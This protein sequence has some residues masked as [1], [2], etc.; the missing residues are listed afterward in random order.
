MRGDYI[1]NPIWTPNQAHARGRDRLINL[2]GDGRD[3]SAE[4]IQSCNA[5]VIVILSRHQ[6]FANQTVRD[7]CLTSLGGRRTSE[8][9]I[10]WPC[11]AA[12]S[13]NG[14]QDRRADQPNEEPGQDLGVSTM[15]ARNS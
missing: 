11:R 14:R 6:G 10:F 8:V 13:A 2:T 12:P 4:F 7:E 1:F 15:T 5:G 9:T 3:R